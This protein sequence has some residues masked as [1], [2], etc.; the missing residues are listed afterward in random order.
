MKSL[1]R[2]PTR[3]GLFGSAFIS[4]FPKT[5]YINSVIEFFSHT[6]S[7]LVELREQQMLS[8]GS[9]SRRQGSPQLF[10]GLQN[11]NYQGCTI[12]LWEASWWF[13]TDTIFFGTPI[14]TRKCF[15]SLWTCGMQ[16]F[17]FSLA[18]RLFSAPWTC[19]N[20]FPAHLVCMNL[21]LVQI[22]SQVI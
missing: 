10:L 5:K 2:Q 7:S 14:C 4:V 19:L 1:G 16:E 12:W 17:F 3:L 20:F 8:C 22:C 18:G 11:S 13:G 9:A 21:N 6:L 15:S